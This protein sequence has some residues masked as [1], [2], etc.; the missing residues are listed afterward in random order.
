VDYERELCNFIR[1][2]NEPW[3]RYNHNPVFLLVKTTNPRIALIWPVNEH[4]SAFNA[5][6]SVYDAI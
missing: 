2:N 3:W 5:L 6:S 4:T 1:P